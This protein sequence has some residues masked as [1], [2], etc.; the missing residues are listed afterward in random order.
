MN[1]EISSEAVDKKWYDDIQQNE[2]WQ[3]ATKTGKRAVKTLV[4]AIDRRM[5]ISAKANNQAGIEY[6]SSKEG[7]YAGLAFLFFKWL[8]QTEEFDDECF[9]HYH[10]PI[11]T[12]WKTKENGTRWATN[13]LTENKEDAAAGVINVFRPIVIEMLAQMEIYGGYDED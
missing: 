3:K 11:L 7:K 6:L 4:K 10:V 2:D 5:K 1:E 13:I 8:M 12:V 9:P